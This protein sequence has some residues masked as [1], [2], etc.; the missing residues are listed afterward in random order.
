MHYLV[1]S[2]ELLVFL[3]QGHVKELEN[4]LSVKAE[5]RRAKHYVSVKESDSAFLALKVCDKNL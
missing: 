4:V 1:T 2:R 3:K 5:A